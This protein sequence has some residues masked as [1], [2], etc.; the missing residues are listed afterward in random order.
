MGDLAPTICVV[1]PAYNEG[2][3]ITE[4]LESVLAQTLPADEI[5]IVD[6]GST[7]DTVAQVERFGDAVRLVRQANAGCAAAFNTGFA[8]TT[9][10]FVALCPADDIWEPH[11]HEWQHEVLVQH[12]DVDVALWRVM[13]EHNVIADPSAG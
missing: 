5:V 10:D 7:D 2:R 13:F 8:D 3:W 6:D 4:T 1:V 12:P 9:A 11:K